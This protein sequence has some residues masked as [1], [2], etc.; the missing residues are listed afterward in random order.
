LDVSN[1]RAL[2]RALEAVAVVGSVNLVD[3]SKRLVDGFAL[4]GVHV[5]ARH[6]EGGDGTSAA[7]A[8]ASIVATE[9]HD[10]LMRQM[11][12]SY[13]EFGFAA[14]K[15]YG[16]SAHRASLIEHG[17][18]AAHRRVVCRK[19]FAALGL[20]PADGTRGRG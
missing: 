2:G 16:T 18:S 14:H 17:V 7:V 10:E 5:S 8:A 20:T 12:D 3:G 19:T 9:T 6:L 4:Q 1:V 11:N 15:G 13:P